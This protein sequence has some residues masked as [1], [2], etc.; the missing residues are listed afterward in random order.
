M[1]KTN[2]GLVSY[3][4][5]QVGKPYWYGTFGQTASASLYK[6]K[7]AQY[8][9][10][11]TANDFTSQYG[12]RVHD[13]VGLINGYL[14]LWSNSATA[15]PTYNSAQDKNASGMYAAAKTKGTISSFPKTKGLLV[16][17]GTSTSKITHVGVYDGS[18]Y[19]YEAKGHSSGVVKSTY[20][21]SNWQYWAQCP[22]T[23]DN[24]SSSTSSSSS[25]TSTTSSTTS[26]VSYY[27]KYTG[28]STKI[29]TVFKAIGV[30]NKYYGSYTK[31]KP[32]AKVN[33]Y[34]SYTGTS[35]QNLAL[36]KLAKKESLLNHKNG[37][38]SY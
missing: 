27:S 12:K 25:S 37:V 10:Y 30:P 7:K 21:S 32:V 20:K 2:S 8:P 35:A 22:Y 6:S 16:F 15:T 31:C 17:K 14:Y 24:T 33:G 23:T 3:A 1:A 34:S 9:S 28:T 4:K 38:C 36:I 19:V 13:C 29:D 5:A 26:S 18:G 11:Y